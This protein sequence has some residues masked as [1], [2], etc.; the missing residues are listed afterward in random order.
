MLRCGLH[1]LWIGLLLPVW[2]MAC[3]EPTPPAAPST[4]DDKPEKELPKT[5]TVD[6]GG[7]VKMEF[8]L[9]PKGKFQMGSPKEE[10]ERNKDEE[11]HEVEI[12]KPFYLAKY[13]VTQEQYLAITGQNPSWFCKDGRGAEKVKDLN[14]KT[15]PVEQVSWTD[16][17]TF[18]EKLREKDKQKRQFHL[19][20]EAQWEYAC[21]AGTTTPFYFGSEL[22]GKQAN[23]NGNHPYGTADNGPFKERTTK[24]GEYGENEWGLCDMHGNVYQWCEDYYGPYNDDLKPTDPLRSAKYSV[25]G[26]VTRGGS[27]LLGASFCRAAHRYELLGLLI[28]PNVGFRVAFRP[29]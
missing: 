8:V 5:V 16:A 10:K 14:T 26:R 21:R 25:E 11:Q 29:D 20:T 13:P 9:I 12:T 24:V 6:L 17:Q 27:W 22:N 18:C 19:P 23:C 1:P 7:D 3:A 2:A 4:V 15:F 28:L